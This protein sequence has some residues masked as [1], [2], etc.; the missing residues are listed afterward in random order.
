M[1]S[2]SPHER[3]CEVAIVCD[4]TCDDRR[5]LKWIEAEA[6]RAYRKQT[7]RCAATG[8]VGRR[9]GTC[10]AAKQAIPGQHFARLKPVRDV[11]AT[12]GNQ[13]AQ[14]QHAQGI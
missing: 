6:V 4:L 5:A 3:A 2:D 9:D 8:R 14:K 11:V 7:L 1:A 13:T 10:P 12:T